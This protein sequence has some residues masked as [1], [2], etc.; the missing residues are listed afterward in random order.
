MQ[1]VRSAIDWT[2]RRFGDAGLVFG[3][4]TDNASDEAAFL[5]TEALGLPF[6]ELARS[7]NVELKASQWAFIVK[8]AERRIAD[9]MPTAYLV[10]RAYIQ[11]FAFRAD[12]RALIPRSFIGELLAGA[13]DGSPIPPLGR[14]PQ[15]VLEL[16]TGSASLAILAAL[17]FPDAH[18]DAVD[19]SAD[20][21]GLAAENVADYG[22]SAR[23]SLLHG[24]LY[25]PVAGKRYDL[26]LSNPP[27]VDAVAMEALPKEYR[28]EPALALAG[29]PDGLD[30]VR[31]IIGGASEHLTSDSG[32]ICEVGTGQTRLVESFPELDLVW[33]A[34][35]ASEG[36][37]FWLDA[38]SAPVQKL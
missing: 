13:V 14:E 10:G 34:T 5:V 19:I 33:L 17:A 22:L 38:V 37:V 24:D 16:G 9:R 1:T 28:H 11:G 2:S 8:L 25:R 31:S 36:E 32:L 12:E 20:A 35:E 6:D 27:Y 29:G 15:S 4:G 18:I 23:V 7:T 21:L 3:H 26:I 30:L